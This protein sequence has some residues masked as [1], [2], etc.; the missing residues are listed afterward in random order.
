[1]TIP[2]NYFI[3]ISIFIVLLYL[4]FILIGS[5][6]GFLF[7]AVSLI[8]TLISVAIAWFMAP[9]LGK[10]FP[11]IH[12]SQNSLEYDLLDRFININETLNTVCYFVIVFLILKLLYIFVSLLMKSLNKI[13]VLG[14]V[15]QFLGA[16]FGFVNATIVTIAIS[17]LLTLPLFRN[18]NEVKEGTILRFI[19]RYSKDVL[20]LI[21]EKTD[22]INLKEE[23]KEIDIESY[24]QQ[25]MEWLEKLNS[26]E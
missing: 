3:F 10:L 23:W 17:M 21:I 24:R 5:H 8:Y 25:F 19:D 7:E 14:N 4:I 20:T 16:V 1:M 9:V 2:E 15:N 26:N 6:Q 12:L 11:L 18:G 13:P 22:G